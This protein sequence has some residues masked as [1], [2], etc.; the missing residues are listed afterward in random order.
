M[1]ANKELVTATEAVVERKDDNA[2]R[3]EF[4]GRKPFGK[5]P[6]NKFGQDDDMTEK[7][8]SIARICKTTK[9][10][11]RMRFRAVVIIGD[12]KGRVG[13]GIGKS[14]EIPVAMRK[15]SKDARKNLIKVLINKKNNDGTVYHEVTAHSGATKVLIKPAPQGS[16]IVAGGV[17]RTVLEL[18]GYKNVCSKNLGSNASLNM[19][20][21]TF[22]CLQSQRTPNRIA[23]LRGKGVKEL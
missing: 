14:I 17:I 19:V 16:G 7:T 9:G 2:A 3:R 21:T 10:G 15:A 18:A 22:K 4:G 20:Q 8:V 1:E 23:Q 12:H 6:F 11:R 13:Y 5:R